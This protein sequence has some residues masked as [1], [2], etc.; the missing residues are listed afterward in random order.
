MI[1]YYF[2]TL[3]ILFNMKGL[4]TKISVV[5]QSYLSFRIVIESNEIITIIAL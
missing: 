3:G 1:C 2:R 4:L 5:S